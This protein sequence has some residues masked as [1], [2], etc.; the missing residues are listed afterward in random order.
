MYPNVIN[1]K[2]DFEKFVSM[3]DPLGHFS[4]GSLKAVTNKYSDDKLFMGSTNRWGKRAIKFFPGEISSTCYSS[5]Y[6]M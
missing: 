3:Y 1:R 6:W 5:L 4:S 2:K